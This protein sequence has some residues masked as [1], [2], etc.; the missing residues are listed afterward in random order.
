MPDLAHIFGQDLQLDNGDLAVGTITETVMQR[1]Y[2]RLC[3]NLG[4]YLWQLDYGA[5]L[6]GRVGDPVQAAEIQALVLHQMEMEAGV[7]QN[8]PPSV[9]VSFEATTGL[10]IATIEFICDESGEP[11]LLSVPVGGSSGT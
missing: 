3:T 7:Q 2:R 1:V 6:P 8:P 9:A 5:G 10:C 4:G 11:V